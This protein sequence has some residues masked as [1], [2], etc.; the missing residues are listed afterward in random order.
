MKVAQILL[1]EDNPADVFLVRMALKENGI[2]HALTRF[3]SGE[4]ALRVL[5]AGTNGDRF[6]PDAILLDLNTPRA[7][8]FETLRRLRELTRLSGVPIAILTSSRDQKD[9]RRAD[10][11]GVRYIEKPTQL[12]EFLTSVSRAVKEMLNLP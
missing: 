3:E 9:K 11:Q 8:G 1:V 5:C 12:N 10:M 6:V 4:D 2:D 7:D